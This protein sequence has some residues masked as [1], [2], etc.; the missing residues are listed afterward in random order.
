MIIIISISVIKFRISS[1]M[2]LFLLALSGDVTVFV[3]SINRDVSN[4]G[5]LVLGCALN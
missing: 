4:V 1:D 5:E 2:L 3:A